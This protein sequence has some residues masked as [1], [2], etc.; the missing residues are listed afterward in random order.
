MMRLAGA[1]L[2]VAVAWPLLQTLQSLAAGHFARV[3]EVLTAAV[4]ARF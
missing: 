2:A 1:V 3:S 4:R